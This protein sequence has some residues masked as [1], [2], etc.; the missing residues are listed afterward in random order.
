MSEE[1]E[2]PFRDAAPVRLGSYKRLDK[3]PIL[4]RGGEYSEFLR[5]NSHVEIVASEETS[6][7][8]VV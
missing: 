1:M 2:R 6:I 3:Y 5:R 4:G 8:S 7:L